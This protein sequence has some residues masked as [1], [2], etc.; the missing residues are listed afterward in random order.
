[1]DQEKPAATKNKTVNIAVLKTLLRRTQAQTPELI[2]FVTSGAVIRNGDVDP[3]L[4]KKISV[5][6]DVD[7]AN[8][9]RQEEAEATSS[10]E[11]PLNDL[12]YQQLIK[13]AL[14]KAGLSY[15]DVQKI[16][17]E[18]VPIGKKIIDDLAKE[19]K[20]QLREKVDQKQQAIIYSPEEPKKQEKIPQAVPGSEKLLILFD[21]QLDDEKV[22][23][24]R[25][26][27]ITRLEE[28]NKDEKDPGGGDEVL[29][30]LARI[31]EVEQR[32]SGDEAKIV[33]PKNVAEMKK[34]YHEEEKAQGFE[35]ATAQEIPG[36]EEKKEAVSSFGENAKFDYSQKTPQQR[37]FDQEPV[38]EN[39]EYEEFIERPVQQEEKEEL[40]AAPII[41]RP[42]PA[43]IPRGSTETE[44]PQKQ[45]Q[46]G[47][48]DTVN[49]LR[50][51]ASNARSVATRMAKRQIGKT[52]ARQAVAQGVR[53][54]MTSAAAATSE[55]TVP[56]LIA[57]IG[58]FI[59]MLAVFVL[60]MMLTGGNDIETTIPTTIEGL[61][62]TQTGPVKVDKNTEITYTITATYNNLDKNDIIISDYLEGDASILTAS[63]PWKFTIDN[64]NAIHWSLKENTGT[65]SF[66]VKVKT[67]DNGQI[68]N[69]VTAELVQVQPNAP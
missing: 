59:I 40:V 55:F 44:Q 4:I 28:M 50:G 39:D 64:V 62:L 67:G 14:T 48:V 33:L 57:I 2:D 18:I 51:R 7:L 69:H 56:V 49:N 42:P 22:K 32:E 36:E 8:R 26:Q 27:L 23:K 65:S 19:A 35:K 45:R 61:T 13:S 29:K 37:F 52:V 24:Y 9:L 30:D 63:M 17:I 15:F 25:T 60:I 58:I 53:T 20:N 31:A 10:P 46:G 5:L 6:I 66:E 1:M 34:I 21:P 3:D 16:P 41:M 68:K 11:K 47:F 54:V 38:S 12:L 43:S